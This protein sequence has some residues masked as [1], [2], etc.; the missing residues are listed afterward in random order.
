MTHIQIYTPLIFQIE[1]PNQTHEIIK[2]YL[3]KKFPDQAFYFFFHNEEN[4]TIGIDEIRTVIKEAAFSKDESHIFIHCLLNAHQ[5]TEQ[6]QNAFLKLLEEP[7]T[8]TLYI[9]QTPRLQTILETVQSRCL[10]INLNQVKIKPPLKISL[11]L[12][13]WINNRQEITYSEI[14]NLISQIKDKK[15]ALDVI[16]DILNLL[17][18]DHQKPA[19]IKE[20]LLSTYQQINQN[21]NVKLAL[22]NCF[23][24]IKTS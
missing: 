24:L 11:D 9:L 21:I 22:E 12:A 16:L 23:F 15:E 20:I 8:Q 2:N 14:I 17:K 13:E 1:E 7:P 4:L 6:A 5:M 3:Y 18:K 10:V 19:I